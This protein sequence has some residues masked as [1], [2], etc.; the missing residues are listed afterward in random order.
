MQTATNMS[1]LTQGWHAAA[2]ME[3]FDE[4]MPTDWQEGWN[5]WHRRTEYR[6]KA[7]SHPMRSVRVH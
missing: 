2:S 6:H 1:E 5:L 3:P 7:E 4:T